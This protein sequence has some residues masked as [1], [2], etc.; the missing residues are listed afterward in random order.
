MSRVGVWEVESKN[1]GE[2][3]DRRFLM[4]KGVEMLELVST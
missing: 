2:K 4:M 1:I 3:C